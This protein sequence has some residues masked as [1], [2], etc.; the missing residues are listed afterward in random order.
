M[1]EFI[2]PYHPRLTQWSLKDFEWRR[3]ITTGELPAY[4]SKTGR[5]LVDNST[6][7]RRKLTKEELRTVAA[8]LR[9]EGKPK[10]HI[11]DWRKPIPILPPNT[12]IVYFGHKEIADW[13]SCIVF[14]MDDV[15][16]FE[17]KSGI[18]APE[19]VNPLKE[20]EPQNI[21]GG[22]KQDTTRKA[23][24]YIQAKRL[25]NESPDMDR[26]RA[27]K[28]VNSFLIQHQLKPYSRQQFDRIT[29][30]LGFPKSQ[31]GRRPAKLRKQ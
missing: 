8:Q 6:V 12:E 22:Q 24:A 15:L 31:P 21:G 9:K 2:S 19:I 30:S 25:R 4:D 17:A 1:T 3:I 27:N 20:G 16:A 11:A 7:A 5:R 23:A 10:Y 26:R 28:L 13:L 29:N 18:A 14:K